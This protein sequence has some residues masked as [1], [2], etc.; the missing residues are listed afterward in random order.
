MTNNNQKKY[1]A[2]Q[3]YILREI[4]GD[5][6]LIPTGNLSMTTNGM[7]TISESAAFL[8]RNLTEEKTA[9]ELVGLMLKEYE[10]DEETVRK[11]I[12]ELIESMCS[13]KAFISSDAEFS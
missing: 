4:A 9:P 5:Y 2:N 12:D 11:D 1:K 3:D 13:I 7:V 10:A 8:W 6:M